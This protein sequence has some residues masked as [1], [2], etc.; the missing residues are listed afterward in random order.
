MTS[1][2]LDDRSVLGREILAYLAEH[3]GSE[4]SL[5]GIVE[6]WLLQ[7]YVTRT[8]AAVRS[9][10]TQLVRRRFVLERAGA[11]G[12]L[13]YRLNPRNRRLALQWAQQPSK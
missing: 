6:W 9:A 10:L 12:R 2:G 3:P 13:T 1:G 7:H 4:D 11:D 8:R 5:E